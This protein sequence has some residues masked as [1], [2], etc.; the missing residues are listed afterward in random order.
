MIVKDQ[1][2]DEGKLVACTGQL[3]TAVDTSNSS[4]WSVRL[5]SGETAGQDVSLPRHSLESYSGQYPSLQSKNMDD[6]L[7]HVPLTAPV[8]S[9][10]LSETYSINKLLG[11]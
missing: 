5:L 3:A 10:L 4:E 9:Q 7:V 2:Q 1:V 8:S 6:V 11:K